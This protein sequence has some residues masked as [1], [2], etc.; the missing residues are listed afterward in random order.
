MKF[1]L[2]LKPILL[3]IAISFCTTAC[4]VAPPHMRY[5]QASVGVSVA[6]VVA[7]APPVVLPAPPVIYYAPPPPAYPPAYFNPWIV[8]N[9]G[10]NFWWGRQWGGGGHHHHHNHR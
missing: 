1:K 7:Y 5:A 6:P 10:L 3:T 9:I 4:V 2:K 8:P